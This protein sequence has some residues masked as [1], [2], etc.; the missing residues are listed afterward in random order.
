MISI[1]LQALT[2]DF[3]YIIVSLNVISN[4]TETFDICA[5]VCS[6]YSI[7]RLILEKKNQ[8]HFTFLTITIQLHCQF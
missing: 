5:S 7:H 8:F 4:N 6:P 3:H 1:P 2:K